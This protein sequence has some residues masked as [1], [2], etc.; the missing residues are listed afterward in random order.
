MFDGDI[1]WRGLVYT[2]LMTLGKL[3]TG[4][5]LVG[6]NVKLP[7]L[8]APLLRPSSPWSWC[9]GAKIAKSPKE[10]ST[11]TRGKAPITSSLS[12]QDVQ[13]RSTATPSPAPW[14]DQ[15]S[16]HPPSTPSNVR[17]PLS[18]YPASIIGT[19]MVARGETGFLISSLA[20]SKGIFAESSPEDIGASRIYLVVTWAI[21]L[22]TITGP[23]AV[24]TL[25]KRVKRL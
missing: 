18:L 10:A 1:V 20:E 12:E 15:N 8:L 17:K 2:I 19:A 13:D 9:L 3:L 21:M 25:V 16:R 14:G 23:V 22:C 6:F 5:W 7:R 24:G 11:R 4:L